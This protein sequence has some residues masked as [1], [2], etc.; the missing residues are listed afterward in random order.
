MVLYPPPP[1]SSLTGTF[2]D[3]E[4]SVGVFGSG[5]VVQLEGDGVVDEWLW[6]LGHACPTVVEVGTGLQTKVEGK[7]Q[8][9]TQKLKIVAHLLI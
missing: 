1:P 3:A 5:V 9:F 7:E 4:G 2:L 8:L 6:A